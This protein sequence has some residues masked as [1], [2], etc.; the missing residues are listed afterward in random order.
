M[1]DAGMQLWEDIA[2]C[3]ALIFST[4]GRSRQ[5]GLKGYIF[6]TPFTQSILHDGNTS[7]YLLTICFIRNIDGISDKLC[8]Y[9]GS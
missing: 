5:V 8:W 3:I 7:T 6:V 2:C 9:S 4:S 1:V